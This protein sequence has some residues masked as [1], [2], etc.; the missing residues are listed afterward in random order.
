MEFGLKWLLHYDKDMDNGIFHVDFV[1]LNVIE[2]EKIDMDY[3]DSLHLNDFLNQSYCVNI[4]L[5]D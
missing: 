5:Q 4:G 3:I 2:K 1:K